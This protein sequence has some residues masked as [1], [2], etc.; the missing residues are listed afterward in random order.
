MANPV[1]IDGRGRKVWQLD[2]GARQD[3]RRD[4]VLAVKEAEPGTV[5]Q[6]QA[7][8]HLLHPTQPLE[9]PWFI[10]VNKDLVIES[11][12]NFKNKA[13][14]F[15]RCANPEQPTVQIQNSD[16]GLNFDMR[17]VEIDCG[18][19]PDTFQDKRLDA[20]RI[21]SAK[22]GI[23]TN[24]HIQGCRIRRAS[25]GVAVQAHVHRE[26]LNDD[27]DLEVIL[28]ENVIEDLFDDRRVNSE[29]REAGSTS[30]GVWHD[31][32]TLDM[33]NNIIR[34]VGWVPG[35]RYYKKSNKSHGLYAVRGNRRIYGN[36]VEDASHTGLAYRAGYTTSVNNVVRRCAIGFEAGHNNS[37]WEADVFSE[38]DRVQ[39]GAH[40]ERVDANG[41][42]QYEVT[43]GFCV[44]MARTVSI[45][46]FSA[47][48]VSGR[49]DWAGL[50]L[51]RL[52]DGTN[53]TDLQVDLETIDVEHWTR[54]FVVSEGSRGVKGVAELV[55]RYE[56]Q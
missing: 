51:R 4:I 6:L 28:I 34:R 45:K 38:G 37:P 41:Q 55:A 17:G 1:I 36:Y 47:W 2:P 22:P 12:P 3:Y 11:A 31:G 29:E 44:H 18:L 40:I 35:S 27:D 21:Q 33:Y 32:G 9:A 50:H 19:I 20:V 5:I 16:N 10:E 49:G 23:K 14:I 7:G 46:S 54:K 24:V 15:G 56:A 39:D 25:G 48:N 43:G 13:V 30:Q 26:G 42:L 53:T 52:T 8:T